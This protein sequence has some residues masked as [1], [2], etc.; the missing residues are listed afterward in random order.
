MCE[1]NLIDIN[2]SKIIS[3]IVKK[4][5][6]IERKKEENFKGELKILREGEN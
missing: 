4:S 5:E 2:M 3:Q 1:Y 6:E